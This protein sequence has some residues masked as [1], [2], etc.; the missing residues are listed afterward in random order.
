VSEPAKEAKE[1][2]RPKVTRF[3]TRD[4][5]NY[6]GVTK[7]TLNTGDMG[8]V[9]DRTPGGLLVR[10]ERPDSKGKMERR[11]T[12]VPDSNVISIDLETGA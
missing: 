9:I 7:N 1:A 12:F 11:E 3:L 2:K 6:G 4:V 8:A 5:V 10:Y